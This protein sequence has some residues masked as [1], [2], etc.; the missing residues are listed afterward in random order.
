MTINKKAFGIGGT[1]SGMF[2]MGLTE[3]SPVMLI[4]TAFCLGIV[5]VESIKNG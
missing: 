4:W 5:V 1:I 3:I 2:L